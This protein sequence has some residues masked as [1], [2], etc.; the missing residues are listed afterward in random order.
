[1]PQTGV[2]PG[3]F[4][5]R[6]LVSLLPGSRRDIY[7]RT[8]VTPLRCTGGA[9]DPFYDGLRREVREETTC[10]D[11]R[12]GAVLLAWKLCETPR[13]G[14]REDPSSGVVSDRV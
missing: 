12:Q 14:R 5:R 11:G 7:P 9:G 13:S 3:L 10:V 4:I 6:S 2:V 1:M 8:G